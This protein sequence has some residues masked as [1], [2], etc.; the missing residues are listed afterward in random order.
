MKGKTLTTVQDF[1]EYAEGLVTAQAEAKA[2]H[3]AE[4]DDLELRT[5]QAEK[6]AAAAVAA[7]EHDAYLH[8]MDD[9]RYF[10]ARKAAV[11][12]AGVHAIPG[13]NELIDTI[14]ALN[15]LCKAQHNKTV[16]KLIDHMGSKEVQAIIAEDNQLEQTRLQ[17]LNNFVRLGHTE[18]SD[19]AARYKSRYYFG[20]DLENILDNIR[21]DLI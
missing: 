3:T 2:K 8:A 16:Q 13:D 21:D 17:A 12:A 5:Q 6:A 18:V 19:T 1:A 4:L 15:E 7:G 11:V 10:E 9:K 14:T 20:I